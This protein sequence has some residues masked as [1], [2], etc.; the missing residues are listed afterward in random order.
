MVSIASRAYSNTKLASHPTSS[1]RPLMPII[2]HNRIKT[3]T[4]AFLTRHLR[5]MQ[6]HVRH[7]QHDGLP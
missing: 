1:P 2:D 3:V 7:F 5:H 4:N 6:A